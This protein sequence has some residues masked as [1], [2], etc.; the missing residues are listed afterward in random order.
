MIADRTAFVAA[1][2][3]QVVCPAG[4]AALFRATNR[5]IGVL[6]A[7]QDVRDWGGFT[8]SLPTPPMFLGYFWRT[9]RG[10]PQ[11]S[12]WESDRN[13]LILIDVRGQSA[14]EVLPYFVRLRQR[15]AEIY[16]T[17]LQAQA[18]LWIT[19]HPLNILWDYA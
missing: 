10:E 17:E 1:T 2:R 16:A 8:Y 11:R 14:D 4:N 13:V 18:A 19:A 3:V 6:L 7:E 9:D 12:G 15:V 5:I